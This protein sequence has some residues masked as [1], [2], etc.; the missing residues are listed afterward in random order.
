MTMNCDTVR[1]LAPAF[2]L[3]ALTADEEQAVREHLASCGDPHPEFEAFGGVVQ[4]LDET[5]EL[6]EPPASLKE[7]VLAAVAAE[8]QPRESGPRA[9][10]TR[11]PVVARSSDVLP[12]VSVVAPRSA[13][14]AAAHRG[15]PGRWLVGVAAVVA[16]VGL[17]GWN[18]LLQMQLGSTTAY[19]R[20]VSAVLDLAAR[21]GSQTAIL[22]A[23]GGGAPRGIAAVGS[24]GSVAVAMRDLEPTAGSQVYETWLIA[25]GGGP[26]PI[27]SFQV[28]ADGRASLTAHAAPESGATIAVTREPGPGATT[29]TLPI[30]S[31]GVATAPSG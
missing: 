7:R 5:V 12:G 8:P 17:A 1:D 9:E 4:Y 15:S 28:A 13:A 14:R 2:V 20:A 31:K 11:A 29:P 10:R 21:P 18:V 24:D 6:I 22:G 26:V 16:I 30:V 25:P 19:D 27:G 23:D 3:G